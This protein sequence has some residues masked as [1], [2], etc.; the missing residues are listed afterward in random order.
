MT[1]ARTILDADPLVVAPDLPVTDLARLLLDNQVEGACVVDGGKLVGVVTAMDLVFKEKNLHLPTIFTFMD[2]VIPLGWRQA[3]KELE[4][5]SGMTV[6]E[7]MS[8]KPKTVG[9]SADLHELA[10][11]MVED[12]LTML[13]VVEQGHLLGVVDKRS[14]LAA[15]FPPTRND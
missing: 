14:V 15:A 7:I 12:H 13:P 6:G 3:E 1:D 10:T 11:L 9:P 5:M 8:S 2:A 4:K